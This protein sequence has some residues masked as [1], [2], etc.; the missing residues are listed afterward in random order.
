VAVGAAPLLVALAANALYNALRFGN[1]ANVGFAASAAGSG[2][3][4]FGN[5]VDG[6]VGLTVEAGHGVIWFAPA[7]LVAVPAWRWLWLKHPSFALSTVVLVGVWIAFHAAYSEWSGGWAWGPRYLLP[8]MALGLVSLAAA[9]ERPWLRPV[10]LGLV[11][12]GCLGAVPGAVTDFMATN[13]ELPNYLSQVCPECGPREGWLWRFAPV[14]SEHALH[15][16]MMA[17]GRLDIAWLTFSA[18]WLAPLTL[19]VSG[20]LGAVGTILLRRAVMGRWNTVA[21]G[22]PS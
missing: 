2:P 18:T 4:F 19:I 13:R 14:N 8:I 15:T 21:S 3:T 5:P 16:W 1:P 7:I 9:W 17:S 12:L 6:L 20:S 10:V 22:R 11:G